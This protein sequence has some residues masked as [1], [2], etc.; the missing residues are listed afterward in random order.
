ME[1][2]FAQSDRPADEKV[3]RGDREVPGEH[4][5]PPPC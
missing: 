1:R 2:N 4:R 5:N 3:M